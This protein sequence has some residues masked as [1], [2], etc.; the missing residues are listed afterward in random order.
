MK[1][2]LPDVLLKRM[3]E[4]SLVLLMDSWYNFNNHRSDYLLI[5]LLLWKRLHRNVWSFSMCKCYNIFINM[6]EQ[7]RIYG[8][9]TNKH[10]ENYMVKLARAEEEVLQTII[11]HYTQND[12]NLVNITYDVFPPYTLGNIKHYLDVLKYNSLISS[13]DQMLAEVD[14][15]LTPDGIEYFPNKKKSIFPKSAKDL[16]VQLLE[17]DNPV[18][19]MQYLFE[20]LDSKTDNRLRAMMRALREEGYISTRW[21]DNVPYYIEFNEKAYTFNEKEAIEVGT[22]N[23][24]IYNIMNGNANI[25]STDNSVRTVT[26]TNNELDLF[27]KMLDVASN[28]K[29]DDKDEVITAIA[30]MRE[31][32]GK[33]T[34]KD[35]YF[36][37]IEVSANHMA[38]FTPFIPAL[39]EMITMIK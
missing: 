32:Y 27:K 18:E 25:N 4:N 28:I 7:M 6:C 8:I 15:F 2:L 22:G 17:K 36:K 37:F 16:L 39:T 38:L 33:P 24:Y 9:H 23:T 3:R 19:Y 26:I 14:I 11:E 34:L 30:E 20:D 10:K 21:A 13:Y 29:E 31:C 35:K 1:R 5:D 12:K